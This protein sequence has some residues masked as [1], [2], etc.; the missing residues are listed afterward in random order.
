[1]LR[2]L[3]L[4]L[5]VV[6]VDQGSKQLAEATLQ[7]YERIP[8][9]PVFN[10]TLAYNRGAAFSF[11]SDQGG[12]QRWLF[13][14][15]AAGVVLVLLLW[16]SRLRSQERLLAASL[17]LIVG[18][19]L[20]NLIDRLLWGHVIDFLDLHYGGWHWP[21]FNLADSA[22]VVGV[23]LFLFDSLRQGRRS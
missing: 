16:L 15:L 8:L 23:G 22:I 11:L 5:L 17:A 18:G 13:T 21:A 7:L 2:W 10:L 9:L 6:A 20:G 3:W 1:M 19:A 14:G 12:W 4:S